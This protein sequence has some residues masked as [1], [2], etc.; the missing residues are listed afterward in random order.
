[1]TIENEIKSSFSSE[2]HKAVVNL[3][4]THNFIVGEL[5]ALFKEHGITLQQFNVLRILRGQFPHSASI[6]LIRERMLDKMS[7]ISRM[8]ERLKKKGLI[9]KKI[10]RKDR[11][12]TEVVI[13]KKGLDLLERLDV[14]VEQ[15][16]N[17][18]SHLDHEEASQLNYLLDKIRESKF[19]L[20]TK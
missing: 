6:G 8:V 4:Y 7:D 13:S 2:Y 1:M 16:N 17:I 20:N 10:S 14:Q 3:I 5:S 9:N 12:S 19:E 18:L 15:A 11:R